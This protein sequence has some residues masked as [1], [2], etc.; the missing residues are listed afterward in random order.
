LRDIPTPDAVNRIKDEDHD[1]HGIEF[2]LS[3]TKPQFYTS[4]VE[5]SQ[6]VHGKVLGLSKVGI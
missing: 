1:T 3:W 4:M 5:A 2:D 6:V